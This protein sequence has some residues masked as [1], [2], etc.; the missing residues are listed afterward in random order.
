MNGVHL[1]TPVEADMMIWAAAG[2]CVLIMLT[3][4]FGW[5][6]IVSSLIVTQLTTI[7]FVVPILM[8][9]GWEPGSYRPAA[10]A[11]GFGGTLVMGAVAT[12]LEKLK[13]DPQATVGWAWRLWKG[14]GGDK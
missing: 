4:K 9:R 14:Q 7:G 11:V 3:R 10:F 6:S 5:A 2:L 1:L 13:D 8:L 12:F